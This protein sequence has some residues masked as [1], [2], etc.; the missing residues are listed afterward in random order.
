MYLIVGKVG[1]LFVTLISHSPF[2]EYFD[3]I[4]YLEKQGEN[5][6]DDDFLLY[7][8]ECVSD[9]PGALYYNEID[10]DY[11]LKRYLLFI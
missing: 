7:S 1:K 6:S 5:V 3:D 2:H 4:F 9:Q 10:R 8:H 11:S